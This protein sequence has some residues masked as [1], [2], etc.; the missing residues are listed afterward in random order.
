MYLSKFRPVTA[1]A[2]ALEVRYRLFY[3]FVFCFIAKFL[4]KQL[5]SRAGMFAPIEGISFQELC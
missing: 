4:V 5:R 3:D 2:Y 1:V